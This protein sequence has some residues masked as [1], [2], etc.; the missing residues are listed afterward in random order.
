MEDKRSQNSHMVTKGKALYYLRRVF[1]EPKNEGSCRSVV[2]L[3]GCAV[4][5]NKESAFLWLV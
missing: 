5:C 4:G 2:L 1:S 3:E